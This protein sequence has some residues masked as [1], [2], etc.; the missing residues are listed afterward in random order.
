[1]SLMHSTQAMSIAQLF[2]EVPSRQFQEVDTSAGS[3]DAA[4]IMSGSTSAGASRPMTA[5]ANRPA[6]P[7]MSSHSVAL[8]SAIK[9]ALQ[10]SHGVSAADCLHACHAH[11]TDPDNFWKTIND[12]YVLVARSSIVT[13]CSCQRCFPL[14]Y[15]FH[16]C[17]PADLVFAAGMQRQASSRVLFRSS[18]TAWAGSTSSTRCTAT[19]FTGWISERGTRGWWRRCWWCSVS[20][21]PEKMWV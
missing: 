13:Q 7:G 15:C 2:P 21:S 4:S 18:D 12:A 14:F 3:A 8:A 19:G 17:L 1:M 9:D 16:P 11:L 6:T 5:A 10:E 20:R